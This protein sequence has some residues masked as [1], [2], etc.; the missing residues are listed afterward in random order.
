M[1]QDDSVEVFSLQLT[2][3]LSHQQLRTRLRVNMAKSLKAYLKVFYLSGLS[4]KSFKRQKRFRGN[5]LAIC[6]HAMTLLFALSF[7]ATISAA[8]TQKTSLETNSARGKFF[9]AFTFYCFSAHTIVLILLTITKKRSEENFWEL[10]NEAE[11]IFKS[12]LRVTAKTRNFNLKCCLKI[13]L[14][15]FIFVSIV[16]SAVTQNGGVLGLTLLGPTLFTQLFVLK[17]VFYVT[18]LQ[19]WLNEI[20]KKMSEKDLSMIEMKSLKK[21][22][23]LC[24][25]MCIVIEKIFGW[26]LLTESFYIFDTTLIASYSLCVGKTLE[27]DGIIASLTLNIFFLL[28]ICNSCQ[29]C[30]DCSKSISSLLFKRSSKD[31]HATIESFALQI[32]H[33]RIAFEPR[34]VFVIN[35]KTLKNVSFLTVNF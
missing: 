31:L 24:W 27:E 35:N 20:K 29:E 30:I 18:V 16:A 12:E 1:S 7:I 33:Q 25:K 10:V 3:R 22:Y 15:T 2:H 13:L 34:N 26:G 5:L 32:L 4:L 6:S 14:P 28:L 11:R 23:T 9:F 8:V 17:F 21:V 19:F